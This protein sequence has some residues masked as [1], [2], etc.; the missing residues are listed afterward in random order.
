MVSSP[1]SSM[2]KSLREQSETLRVA[3]RHDELLIVL[4]QLIAL[5]PND[6]FA[7]YAKADALRVLGQFIEAV[8]EADGAI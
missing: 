6:E 5:A 4:D 1:D 3:E 7:H 8:A 2:I